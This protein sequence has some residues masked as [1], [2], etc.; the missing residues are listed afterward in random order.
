MNLDR[1]TVKRPRSSSPSSPAS[2]VSFSASPSSSQRSPSLSP[3]PKYHRPSPS[4]SFT[5]LPYTCH[6]APTCSQPSNSTSYATLRELDAHQQAFHRWICRTPIRVRPSETKDGEVPQSFM[7]KTGEG[8][9]GW[10]E[11]GKAFPEERLLALVSRNPP[12]S[13]RLLRLH[14]GLIGMGFST[15]LKR[16]TRSQGNGRFAGRRL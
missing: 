8:K 2:F 13:S 14:L 4:T 6:L 15:R 3:A 12:I 11:C 10:R 7:R 16:M 9:L 1:S 5:P